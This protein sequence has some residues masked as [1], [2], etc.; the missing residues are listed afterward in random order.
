MINPSD[1]TSSPDMT[2]NTNRIMVVV[3]TVVFAGVEWFLFELLRMP[4]RPPHDMSTF[5]GQ[6]GIA[7]VQ[8]M[9]LLAVGWLVLVAV[10]AASL[11][12]TWHDGV[13]FVLL[14]AMLIIGIGLLVR[15]PWWPVTPFERLGYWRAFA[16]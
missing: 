9:V 10:W 1:K 13:G 15:Y 5:L 11:K 12:Y 7:V 4:Y 14:V 3:T 6:E 16:S 2:A 8:F